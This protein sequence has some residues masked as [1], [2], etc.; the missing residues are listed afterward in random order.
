MEFAKIKTVIDKKK[1]KNPCF[2]RLSRTHLPTSGAAVIFG[3]EH[4]FTVLGVQGGMRR[5][6]PTAGLRKV[7]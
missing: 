3:S 4:K 5:P 7:G 2:F 1:E 6:W